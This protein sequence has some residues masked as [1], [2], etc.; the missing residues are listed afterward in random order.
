MSEELKILIQQKDDL[1][2]KIIALNEQIKGVEQAGRSKISFC[3]N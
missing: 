1:E 2:K 3:K